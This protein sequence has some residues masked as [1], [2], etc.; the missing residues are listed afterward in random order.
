[1]SARSGRCFFWKEPQYQLIRRPGGPHRLSGRLSFV[2]F[3]NHDPRRPGLYTTVF[4]RL[5]K[6]KTKAV[7]FFCKVG[8][9]YQTT[10]CYCPKARSAAQF[11]DQMIAAM[12]CP[13][14]CTLPVNTVT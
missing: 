2:G 3:L 12:K 14:L 6:A 4:S 10:R 9:T 11:L 8:T 13:S 7:Y 5:P 1:V